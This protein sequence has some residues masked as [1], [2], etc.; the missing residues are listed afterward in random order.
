MSGTLFDLLPLIDGWTF[1][2]VDWD[3]KKLL[4]NE[5]EIIYFERNELG[6]VLGAAMLFQ[7]EGAENTTVTIDSGVGWTLD[8]TIQMQYLSG[9]TEKGFYYPSVTRYDKEQNLFNIVF[10]PHLTYAFKNKIKVS[11]TPKSDIKASGSLV[12]VKITDKDRFREDVKKLI[13]GGI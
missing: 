9:Q 10:E 3:N 4:A 5:E 1:D 2:P 12:I 13:G 6:W 8:S 11:V 7:G